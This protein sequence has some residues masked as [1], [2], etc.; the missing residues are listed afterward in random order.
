MFTINYNRTTNHID[1][2]NI[3]TASTAGSQNFSQNAC[4]T[5]T[6]GRLATGRKFATVAEALEAARK[7]GRK[8]CGTCEKAAIAMMEAEKAAEIETPAPAA[9]KVQAGVRWS[10]PRG[11]RRE[12]V[13]VSD[14]AEANKMIE[15]LRDRGMVAVHA[16]A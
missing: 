2:L 9:P 8:L 6:R 14:R 15:T 16:Y 5:L 10:T 13:P 7:G 12:F 11:G 3:R 1:G 4:G